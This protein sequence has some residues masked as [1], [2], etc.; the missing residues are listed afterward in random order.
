[1]GEMRALFTGDTK[2]LEQ[3]RDRARRS[4]RELRQE[5]A[6][7]S[8]ETDR[9]RDAQSR[10][11]RAARDVGETASRA[12]R[13]VR[14]LSQSHR[15]GRQ[16][17][18][19]HAAAHEKLAS[20][21]RGIRALTGEL[22][23]EAAAEARG[24]EEAERYR[25][26]Q[27]AASQAREM[28][29]RSSSRM[30]K[31]IEQEV[32]EQARLRAEI[33]KTQEQRAGRTEVQTNLGGLRQAAADERALAAAAR[34]SPESFSRQ[35]A[36]IRARNA[37]LNIGAHATAEERAEAEKL[38]REIEEQRNEVNKL[39]AAHK[40]G[41][42]TG[43]G[44]GRVVAKVAA[45]TAAFMILKGI[46]LSVVETASQYEQLR[47]QLQTVT[48]SAEAAAGAFSLI[49]DFAVKTPFEVSNITTAFVRLSAVGINPTE[50]LLRSL[51]DTSAAFGK[52]ITE[53]TQAVIGATTGETESLKAFGIVARM[54]GDKVKFTFKGVTTEVSRDSA[55]IVS[56]LKGIGDTNF[57]GG[58]E[59]QSKS[60]AGAVS[61][62]KDAWAAFADEVG[63]AGVTEAIARLAKKITAALD[64]SSGSAQKMGKAIAEGID[65]ASKAFSLLAGN[66]DLA[67]GALIAYVSIAAA[68]TALE[69]ASA[70][71]KAAQAGKLAEMSILGINAAILKSPLGVF[72]LVV[73]A[74]LGAMKVYTD[75]VNASYDAEAAYLAQGQ[76]LDGF[77]RDLTDRIRML[78]DLKAQEATASS[79]AK[80]RKLEEARASL[81]LTD[82]EWKQAAGILAIAVARREQARAEV[83]ALREKGTKGDKTYAYVPQTKANPEGKVWTGYRRNEEAEQDYDDAMG[84]LR[85]SELQYDRLNG[86]LT[87][88]AQLGVKA[89]GET[90]D[91]LD[92]LTD[93]QD[94]ARESLARYIAD[95]KF[96]NELKR[97]ILAAEKRGPDQGK[98]RENKADADRSVR[99]WDLKLKEEGLK[100]SA[101]NEA[102]IRREIKAGHDLDSALESTREGRER[103]AAAARELRDAEA[104]LADLKAGNVD[105]SMRAAAAT[106]AE[107]IALSEG[108]AEEAGYV[109]SLTQEILA[110]DKKVAVVKAATAAGERNREHAEKMAMLSAELRDLENG[111]TAAT[112]EA[113][114]AAEAEAEIRSLSADEAKKQG[115]AI[116]Q[117][118]QDQAEE[119]RAVEADI[120][121][122]TRQIAYRRQLAGMK[123]DF[124][125]WQEQARAAR[126]Y[127]TEIAGI[128][129]RYGLLS[130]ATRQLRIEEEILAAIR[131]E[132]LDRTNP[133]HQERIA[134]I[135]A[136][137]RAQAAAVDEVSKYQAA[138]EMA[139]YSTEPLREAWRST[140]ETIQG[141]I[142]DVLSGTE[143]D[144]KQLIQSMLQMW[145]RAMLEMLVR[146]IATQKAMAAYAAATQAY[147]AASGAGA[148]SGYGSLFGMGAAA[149]AYGAGGSSSGVSGSALAGYALAA[150]AIFVIYKGFIEDHHKKFAEITITDGVG[151]VTA[152][153]GKKYLEGVQTAAATIAKNLEQFLKEVD[154]QMEHLG[155]VIITSSKTGW[156]VAIP[157]STGQLFKSMDEAISYAQV[158]QLKYGEFASSVSFLV[159]SVIKSSKAMSVQ[160]LA[161]DIGFAKTLETQ[162]MVQV[163][164]DMQ[165]AVDLAVSQWRRA[166]ELFMSF[167]DRNLPA[168]AEAAN[169]IITKLVGS[170][171]SSFNQLTGVEEDPHEKWNRE[172]D[173]YNAQ[174]AITL[175]QLALWKMEIDQRIANYNATRA[176]VGGMGGLTQ[177]GLTYAAS[178]VAAADAMD[179]ALQ[180]LLDIQAQLDAAIKNMP[181]ELKPEDY[182]GT[183]GHHGGGGKKEKEE[184]RQEARDTARRWSLG[185]TGDS[186]LDAQAE[187]QKYKDSL[188]GLGLTAKEQA[189]LMAAADEEL[190]RK[191][192][193]IKAQV[194]DRAEEFINRGTALGGPLLSS[195]KDID[196]TAVGLTKDT[197][198][199]YKTGQLTK[200]EMRE[201]NKQIRDAAKAQKEAAITKYGQDI[202]MDLYNLLGM[203]EEAAQLKY[204]L[205]LAELEIRRAELEIALIEHG[206]SLDILAEIDTLI[207]KV[208]EAGPGLF[209]PNNGNSGN[210]GGGSGGYTTPPWM[211]VRTEIRDQAAQWRAAGAEAEGGPNAEIAKLNARLEELT[212][213]ARQFNL[214]SSEIPALIEAQQV[215]MEAIWHSLKKGLRDFIDSMATG[216]DDLSAVAPL[217]GMQAAQSRFQE[218]L[219]RAQG[220]DANAYEQLPDVARTLLEA[221]QGFYG[222]TNSGA[223]RALYD[224]IMGAIG[225]LAGTGAGAVPAASAAGTSFASNPTGSNPAEGFS[226]IGGAER[227][228]NPEGP[229]V[230]V[231]VPPV[232]LDLEPVVRE[233][234]A[235]KGQ[236][237]SLLS[238]VAALNGLT[239]TGNDD[240]EDILTIAR[241]EAG[242]APRTARRG[243]NT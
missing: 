188:K 56:Y 182:P 20:G 202:L 204:D 16:N 228:R 237:N 197:R 221:A 208:R 7:T 148:G 152:S 30:G 81:A 117:A 190:K 29:I 213:K 232:K 154:V 13:S 243:Y 32:F 88:L 170:L 50:D 226:V 47:L 180:A 214:E 222:G 36:A 144:W 63:K 44:W 100:L 53:F 15:D 161:D 110:Q 99:E 121:A 210:S 242:I 239:S 229:S 217:Q 176:Y 61:N 179:P 206:L 42:D 132:S 115:A 12:A 142:G 9:G 141:V 72:L 159:K 185:D 96:E 166:E 133:K 10:Y 11:A 35:A 111:S 60:M 209:M 23:G 186:V 19:R 128:L 49:K 28:G 40:T 203:D 167:Y 91:G 223:Y 163:G 119:T 156:N 57:A 25:R 216:L 97:Q 137:V 171:Q 1:M 164:R 172:K 33:K 126:Q 151:D 66:I 195:L 177:K 169:S 51:G 18:E 240:R 220:G 34:E 178:M 101:D 73:G 46:I 135:E 147:T 79:E 123:A 105:A 98:E 90:K 82:A 77:Y 80:K 106:K 70:L 24:A 67:K 238:Q 27:D 165:A 55:S 78:N 94:K 38:T 89:T 201:L 230:T 2:G 155:T 175:A 198:D 127:G 158:L 192:E 26:A 65:L 145:I 153:H 103:L 124:S 31:V 194:T 69:L 109:E 234:A 17:A 37:A 218:V 231:T 85:E 205:T 83:E 5:V 129:G 168:F 181:P 92:K 113:T 8:R 173:A 64:D 22:R 104:E 21:I 95:L 233:L 125:D 236:M 59:R 108:R 118:H 193:E 58:M 54:E 227:F 122:K 235:L 215:A 68:T 140:G 84:R 212:L 76:E 86:K 196:K 207:G 189:A 191:L 200:Q 131:D 174:R 143:V 62:V 149:K 139:A 4:L 120:A 41:Q 6:D 48:G 138:V 45:V 130:S 241:S 160:G 75:R 116:R 199:L 52:D 39:N 136:E 93:S 14:E 112:R 146:W 107:A 150:Y 157:N 183:K 162:N 184:G 71:T 211:E 74:A 3:A 219:T 43:D 87:E 187:I 134:Q 102:A 224:W 114:A 225:Q